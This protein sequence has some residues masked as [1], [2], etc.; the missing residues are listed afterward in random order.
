MSGIK[1]KFKALPKWQKI[2]LYIFGFLVVMALI[3]PPPEKETTPK[4]SDNIA[5]DEKVQSDKVVKNESKEETI[6]DPN[7]INNL[8]LSN[9]YQINAT[10]CFSVMAYLAEM[11]NESLDETWKIH[12]KRVDEFCGYPKKANVSFEEEVELAKTNVAGIFL[13]GDQK[14]AKELSDACMPLIKA[15]EGE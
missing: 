2:V 5:S 12:A 11:N 10:K 1:D 6:P 8:T 14:S 3:G 15:S 9:G 4:S 7:C 13:S